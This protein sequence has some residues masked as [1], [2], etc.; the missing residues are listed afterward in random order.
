M[1]K[2]GLL[3]TALFMPDPHS[4][5]WLCVFSSTP[6]IHEGALLANIVDAL[7]IEVP[8]TC[9]FARFRFRDVFITYRAQAMRISISINP[10]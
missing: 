1:P 5:L 6:H 2:T 7:G 3:N 9:E 10:Y 4:G 8:G